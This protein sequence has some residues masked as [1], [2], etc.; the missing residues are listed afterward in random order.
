MYAVVECGGRQYRLEPGQQV[1]VNRMPGEKGDEIVLD[2]VLLVSDDSGTRVGTPLVEGARV[3]C[4]IVR[5]GRG[6]KIHGFQFKAK[7]NQYRH[8]GHRQAVT[9][10]SVGSIA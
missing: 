6:R 3:T 1:E 7:K 2:R 9:L 8:Y 4:N 5:Q 10:L